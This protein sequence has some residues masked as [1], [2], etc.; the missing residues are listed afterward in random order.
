MSGIIYKIKWVMLIE[1]MLIHSET[2][3]FTSKNYN[4]L[5]NFLSLYN[6]RIRYHVDADGMRFDCKDVESAE[7]LT[8]RIN[9]LSNRKTKYL[10]ISANNLYNTFEIKD[11]KVNGPA[12]IVFWADGTKT[13][14]KCGPDDSYDV[15]KAVAMCFMKKALGSRSMKKL[16]DLAEDKAAEYDNQFKRLEFTDL[17]I[18]F[19]NALNAIFNPNPGKLYEGKVTEYKIPG[20]KVTEYKIPEDKD[21]DKE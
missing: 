20:G 18:Y 21:K 17:D 15:E 7:V 13:V 16:F 14:V 11:I 9:N 3:E 5:L 4:R 10:A 12:T 1:G 8:N 6:D 2:N 19:K